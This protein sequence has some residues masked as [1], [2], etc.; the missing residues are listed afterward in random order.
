MTPIDAQT[1]QE[2]IAR[3]L[4]ARKDRSTFLAQMKQRQQQ[5]WQVA[6][7]AAQ[8]LKLEFGAQRVVL[9]GSLLDHEGMTW[10]SDI[11]LA[12]WGVD[13]SNYLRAGAAI[14]REQPFSIN[15]IDPDSA[16]PHILEAIQQG[17]DL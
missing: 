9:F 5:G 6:R 15:L 12:V 8:C 4:T 17:T 1:R 16:P 14:E 10:Y 2:I 11:D 13:A 3:V 7:K